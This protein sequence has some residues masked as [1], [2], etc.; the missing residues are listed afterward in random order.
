MD[1]WAV[2]LL[3]A[4]AAEAALLV[5]SSVLER[6]IVDPSDGRIV[7]PNDD[8]YPAQQSGQSL[9]R[10]FEAATSSLEIN[11]ARN[12]PAMSDRADWEAATRA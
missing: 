3:L 6:R 5:A 11:A 12:G 4:P 10:S 1:A 8:S 9:D 7:D 2:L